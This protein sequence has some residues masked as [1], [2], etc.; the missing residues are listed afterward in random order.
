MQQEWG[1]VGEH[2]RQGTASAKD[3]CQDGAR[4]S[5]SVRR[6]KG[7]A[8]WAKGQTARDGVSQ[9]KWSG[10]SMKTRKL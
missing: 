9:V 10:Q 6:A 3:P 1:H 8:Q 7:L 4:L 5:G 2:S